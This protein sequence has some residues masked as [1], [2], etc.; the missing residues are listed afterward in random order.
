METIPE[1]LPPSRASF[2]SSLGPIMHHFLEF[3]KSTGSSFM[4]NAHPNIYSLLQPVPSSKPNEDPNTLLHYYNMFDAIVDAAYY[5]MEA[6]NFSKIPV[7]LTESRWQ[8][9]M[10]DDALLYDRALISEMLS[11]SGTPSRPEMPVTVYT[12]EEIQ[13]GLSYGRV[14]YSVNFQSVSHAV[15]EAAGTGSFCVALQ[16]AD[17]S[18]LIAGL[19]WACGPGGANCSAIQQGQPC[20]STNLVAVAS[21]AYNDYYQR[22]RSTGGT[23]SFNNTA[24][25][26]SNDPSKFRPI[27]DLLYFHILRSYSHR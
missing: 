12:N 19:N 15:T 7:V 21:Y 11:K 1:P 14:M 10:I 27:Y 3:L 22:T 4:L 25:L 8:G 2:N 16:N 5:S 18:A 17:T 23:C 9:A 26:T 20:Y 13:H 24:T 6:L